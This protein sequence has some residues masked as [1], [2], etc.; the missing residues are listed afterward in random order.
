VARTKSENLKIPT[1]PDDWP[2]I[3]TL[4]FVMKATGKS[5]TSIYRDMDAGVFPPAYKA[6]GTTVWKR[7]ELR[8]WLDSLAA[9]GRRGRAA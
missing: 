6:G 7:D 4:A 8:A 9:V 5:R 2:I 1:S 3:L